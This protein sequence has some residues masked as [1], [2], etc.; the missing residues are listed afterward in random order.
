M[1]RLIDKLLGGGVE[2]ITDGIDTLFT[3]KEEKQQLINELEAMNQRDRESA[4][5]MYKTDS[6]LQKVYALTFLIGYILLTIFFL[7]FIYLMALGAVEEIDLPEWGNTLLSAIWGAIT[8]KI[9]TITDFLFGG[10]KASEQIEERKRK[11]NRSEARR[12]KKE[13]REQ[14]ELRERRREEQ[15]LEKKKRERQKKERQKRQNR[16]SQHDTVG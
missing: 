4:R 12:D 16:P 6:W 7:Y 15:Q 8:M 11:E 10:A 3:S 5:E 14:R 1:G 13:R 2:A 9:S